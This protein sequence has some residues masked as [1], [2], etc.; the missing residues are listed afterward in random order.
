MNLAEVKKKLLSL[1]SKAKQQ[2]GLWKPS[3]GVQVVRIVPYKFNTD[4][5]FIE[6]YFHYGLMGKTYLSPTSFGRP[7]PLVDFAEKLKS[8]GSKEDYQ[9]SRQLTPK[10]RV[11]AP[12]L[13]RG[14]ES[15][16]VKFWGFG[17]QVYEEL[18]G[19]IQDPDYGDIAD[20]KSGRDFTIEFTKATSDKE[21]PKTSIRVKPNQVPV[22]TDK[23][24]IMKIGEQQEITTFFPEPSY[25]DL[26]NTLQQWLDG[27][28]TPNTN[29]AT[30]VKS[31]AETVS[32][33]TA[34]T[35]VD[36]VEDAFDNLFNS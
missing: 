18:L 19:I 9:L 20:P 4:Y 32:N 3:E 2:D 22:S 27:D 17:K 30:P 5:P 34:T 21:F 35:K 36:D 7:D 25:D 23:N 8:S 11:Y 15:D 1:Q 26:K 16:G 14:K 29:G 13:V 12:I 6:L 31:E 33:K 24:I 28:K 10:M